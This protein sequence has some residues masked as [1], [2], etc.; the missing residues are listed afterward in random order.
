MRVMVLQ[1]LEG[2]GITGHWEKGEQEYVIH[3]PYHEAAGDHLSLNPDKGVYQCWSCGARGLWAELWSRLTQAN[4]GVDWQAV[5]PAASRQVQVFD[6]K[7][8]EL[9]LARGFSP[10]CLAAWEVAWDASMKAVQLPVYDASRRYA[11]CIW[12]QP[13][14]REPKYLYPQGFPKSN[15]LFGQYNLPA[16]KEVVLSEGPLDA[17]WLQEAGLPGVAV[18][19]S[20]LSSQQLELLGT[21]DRVILCFDNDA[22]G[23][24]AVT[25]AGRALRAVG[26]WVLR[27]WLPSRYKDI[28]DVPLQRVK[29][30][31][32]T[33]VEPYVNSTG[34]YSIQ[35]AGLADRFVVPHDNKHFN[36]WR[37]L[38]DTRDTRA[39]KP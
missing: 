11:G 25:Q 30:L 22:A 35:T 15:L 29:S 37:N 26:K 9:L 20:S 23:Q 24:Q 8:L 3:C 6:T 16:S 7:G 39:T 17:I 5:Q 12:R 31:F 2:L 28:Q 14:G 1:A 34:L 4:G 18:L 38:R 32:R 19:G 36:P 13:E 27:L 33:C 21:A 10:A